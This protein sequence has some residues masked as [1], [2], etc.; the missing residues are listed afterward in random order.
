M[1]P[2]PWHSA[3]CSHA[4]VVGDWLICTLM[5]WILLRI[6]FWWPARVT[7]ILSKSLGRK[8]QS[9]G[10]KLKHKNTFWSNSQKGFS[11]HRGW[12][13]F[14]CMIILSFLSAAL[15]S[16]FYKGA[17]A[18]LE[19]IG[20]WRKTQIRNI[21]SVTWEKTCGARCFAMQKTS[22]NATLPEAYIFNKS[23]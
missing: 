12:N 15:T 13:G 17:I 7:P 23:R 19:N 20:I 10:G 2:A 8:R 21:N 16:F 5:D 14:I 4:I 6:F 18:A 3:S 22:M 1:L 11:C 9:G